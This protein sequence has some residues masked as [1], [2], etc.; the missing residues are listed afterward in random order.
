M[1]K[2]GVLK[3]APQ[4][5]T[6]AGGQTSHGERR[7]ESVLCRYV[8]GYGAEEQASSPRRK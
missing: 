4:I 3:F 7:V 6:E 8:G 5:C 2:H 1:E